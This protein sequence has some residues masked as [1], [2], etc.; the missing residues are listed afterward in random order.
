MKSILYISDLAEQAPLFHSQVLPHVKE[1]RIYFEVTLLVM[2]RPGKEV[3]ANENEINYQSLKGD[4]IRPV[5][6]F[7]FLG[8]HRKLSDRIR[9]KTFDLI[10]S[11]GARGGLAGAFIKRYIFRNGVPMLNDVR[12]DSLDGMKESLMNRLIVNQTNKSII[13]NSDI[14]FMVSS[15]LK[16]KICSTYQ[17]DEN[18]AFVF[19]TFVLDGKF[20]F[21]PANRAAIRSQLQFSFDDIVIVYSGNLASYQNVETIIS[22]F[23][24]TTNKRLKLL[25][26]TQDQAIYDIVK[27]LKVRDENIK[28]MNVRYGEIEKYYHS[29][30]YG[31]LIR[32]D[33]DTNKSASPTKFSEY[34]NSGLA[35]IINSIDAEYVRQFK[36]KKLKGILLEN[37]HD[38][39]NCFN[40]MNGAVQERNTDKINL[41]SEVVKKQ[42]DVLTKVMSR[43]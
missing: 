7:N 40:M 39:L 21:D 27:K 12:G 16:N 41:L 11:R 9:H 37:K 17:F 14:L 30:D 32:D 31:V 29:A 23:T 3:T 25:F 13:R 22:A 33:I 19:P 18:K 42:K 36:S 28:V 26:L 38:L 4:Y 35:V 1:L 6:F 43:K 5:S 8:Q 34:I 20:D 24:S 10:Y 15:F 2:R